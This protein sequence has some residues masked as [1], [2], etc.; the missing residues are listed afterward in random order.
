MSISN[1]RSDV[2]PSPRLRSARMFAGL[3]LLVAVAV[4]APA[5]AGELYQWK[6]AN[7]VTH[8]SDSPPPGKA[9][10]KNRTI[11]DSGAASVAAEKAADAP[12]ANNQCTTARGNLA[13]LEGD[14]PVGTD[15]DKDGKPDTAFTA[16]ER[17]AQHEL[18][19]AAINVHCS[20]AA[21]VPSSSPTT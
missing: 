17:S 12:A 5:V 2:R 10:Y 11:A 9:N 20:D 6:D 1:S 8:Y 15:T 19:K 13:L 7:G 18:A 21:A 14:G 16:A 4:A 3:A